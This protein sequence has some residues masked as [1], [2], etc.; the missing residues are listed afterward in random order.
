MLCAASMKFRFSEDRGGFCAERWS[1]GK[2]AVLS[3]YKVAL[4]PWVPRVCG[5]VSFAV[6]LLDPM[7]RGLKPHLI[8]SMRMIR[9]TV[10]LLDPMSRGLKLPEAILKYGCSSIVAL[11]DPMSRGLKRQFSPLQPATY[12][13]LH[14]LTRWVGDWNSSIGVRLD[15]I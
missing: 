2:P 13:A 14:C 3:G 12:W 1:S 8:K 5:F 9:V 15:S 11:L 6:A 10:A 4:K 7:S